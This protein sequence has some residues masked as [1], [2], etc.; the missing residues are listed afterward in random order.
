[1][2]LKD[3]DDIYVGQGISVRFSFR[4]PE[5]KLPQPSTNP[6]L[7]F[8]KPVSKDVVTPDVTVDE[9]NKHYGRVVVDEPGEWICRMQSDEPGAASKEFKFI[10]KNSAFS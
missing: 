9:D 3:L 6:I 8:R 1:M 5:T 4:D 7:L 2:S 10:V